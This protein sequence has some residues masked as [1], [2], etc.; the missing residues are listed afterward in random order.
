[1]VQLVVRDSSL[2]V[3][4]LVVLFEFVDKEAEARWMEYQEMVLLL[5]QWLKQQT[6]NMQVRD[7]PNNPTELHALHSQYVHFKEMELLPKESEK[8]R[9]KNVYKSLEP[10]IQFGHI[11]LPQGQHP[12]DIE[13][14]WGRLIVAMLER[15]KEL[16]A[17]IERL[18]GLQHLAGKIQ[19][20]CT[21][22]EDTL[23]QISKL[24]K[25]DCLA[26]ETGRSPQH[27]REV[28][29]MLQELDLR[30]RKLSADTQTL[31]DGQYFQAEQDV[32]RVVQLQERLSGLRTKFTALVDGCHIPAMGTQ[33]WQPNTV[34]SET[35]TQYGLKST[36][37]QTQTASK[38]TK[39][40]KP[41][42][43]D[44]ALI[45]LRKAL[46]WVEEH[47]AELEKIEWGTD[48]AGVEFSLQSQ[49]SLL[50]EVESFR[51]KLENLRT[52]QTK[53]SSS[54]QGTYADSLGRLDLLYTR[55]LNSSRGRLKHLENLHAFVARATR[56][57]MWLNEKEEEEISY[58]WGERNTD[59]GTKQ[60]YHEMFLKDLEQKEL[61]LNDLRDAGERMLLT[62][63]PA[64][65]TIEVRKMIYW[66][67]TYLKRELVRSP[68]YPLNQS[69][70]ILGCH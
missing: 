36:A 44:V 8:V 30:L 52:Q 4:T 46:A 49:R 24:I 43:D 23:N 11:R 55:L 19:R 59:L 9:I 67:I 37:V 16:R 58:D 15:E 40:V 21:R 48:L 12:N 14:E 45:A 69:T 20:E 56:E 32:S 42:D 17:E 28:E 64:K 41:S 3:I 66:H 31:Q 27:R 50:R 34:A 57:L 25:A 10:W 61:D 68:T 47:Q 13:K 39:G 38:Q 65:Q 2:L 63:H 70:G 18:E 29:A 1:M 26:V 22:C 54:N 33:T 5:L 60:E 62:N 35:Q 6:L 53:V 7:F 51:H